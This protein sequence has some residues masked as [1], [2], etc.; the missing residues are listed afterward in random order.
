MEEE[1]A[2]RKKLEEQAAN[3]K[4]A[5]ITYGFGK[6]LYGTVPDSWPEKY[7]GKGGYQKMLEESSKLRGG[8]VSDEEEMFPEP[9]SPKRK[10]RRFEEKNI[11]VAGANRRDSPEKEIDITQGFPSLAGGAPTFGPMEARA[12]IAP[13]LGTPFSPF[14][15]EIDQCW[16]QNRKSSEQILTFVGAESTDSQ[17]A[18]P[19]T[20]EQIGINLA[21]S[22][23]ASLPRHRGGVLNGLADWSQVPIPEPQTKEEEEEDLR[24]AERVAERVHNHIMPK[25]R[26]LVKKDR[27]EAKAK[28]EAE[29]EE[30][31]E[32]RREEKRNAKNDR[33]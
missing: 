30:R 25:V 6:G 31:R 19:L 3:R 16:F 28:K 14:L 22:I 32:A 1:I 26:E 27:E 17:V 18:S 15:N 23:D 4:A 29:K 24:L 8:D 21:K 11:P 9:K 33:S 13:S 10:R 20:C 2:K 12:P 7:G 5:G